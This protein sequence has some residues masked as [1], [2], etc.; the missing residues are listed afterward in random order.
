MLSVI[1]VSVTASASASAS[2]S[3]V[4]TALCPATEGATFP[5]LCIKA[6]TSTSTLIAETGRFPFVSRIETG[7][8]AV[9][10]VSLVEEFPIRI[11]CATVV[12]AGKF[13]Q[14]VLKTTL[15]VM[16]LAMEF[17]SCFL[18]GRLGEVC[19]VNE[20]MTTNLLDAIVANENSELVD[21]TFQPEAGTQWTQFEL[22][23]RESKRCPLAGRFSV[24]GE[25][26]CWLLEGKQDL[27]VHLLECSPE[28]SRTLHIA[29]APTTFLLTEEM[30]LSEANTSLPWSIELA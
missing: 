16:N 4:T 15:L 13:E 10:E 24:T 14:T 29:E 1:A 17:N 22:V 2:A 11:V 5:A 28:G 25:L 27:V 23:D 3:A 21:V 26:L 18:S 12:A 6:T 9:L 20:R 7:Q 8:E 19:Q 30:R